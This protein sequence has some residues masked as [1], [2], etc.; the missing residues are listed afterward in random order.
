MITSQ[1]MDELSSLERHIDPERINSL[2]THFT[3][4]HWDPFG[5]E[6]LDMV[7]ASPDVDFGE[8]L[9]SIISALSIDLDP[10][11]IAELLGMFFLLGFGYGDML[12]VM[13]LC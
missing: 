12:M 3:R 1:F 6:L 13:G 11:I 8:I 4:R 10:F 2:R 9:Q 5:R 7:Y